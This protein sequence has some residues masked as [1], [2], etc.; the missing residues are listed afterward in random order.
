MQCSIRSWCT[1]NVCN[2]SQIQYT[3]SC[4]LF[5]CVYILYRWEIHVWFSRIFQCWFTDNGTFTWFSWFPVSVDLI[6]KGVAK[7]T[8]TINDTKH[9]S[10]QWFMACKFST[11]SPWWRHGM[12]KLSALRDL[13][14]FYMN[15]YHLHWLSGWEHLIQPAS[16]EHVLGLVA[17]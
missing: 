14:T 16:T 15:I 2:V 11:P 1:V 5:G 10:S 17:W 13:I 9:T 6:M 8:E 3:R 4:F 12:E 7:L